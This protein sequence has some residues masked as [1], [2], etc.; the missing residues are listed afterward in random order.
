MQ[1]SPLPYSSKLQ[2]SNFKLRPP[3]PF[4]SFLASEPIRFDCVDGDGKI[5]S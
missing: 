5:G 2:T 3:Y 4:L 1:H